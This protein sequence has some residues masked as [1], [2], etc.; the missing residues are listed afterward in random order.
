LGA[1]GKGTCSRLGHAWV[2]RGVRTAGACTL[3]IL[4]AGAVSSC[5]TRSAHRV[6]D[7]AHGI[8]D[9]DAFKRM[10]HALFDAYDRA[11]PDRFAEEV[12]PAFVLIDDGRADDR[13]AVIGEIR[14]RRDRHAPNRSRTTKNEKVWMGKSSAVFF[15]ETIEHFLPDGPRIVGDVDGYVTLVWTND[16]GLWKVASWQWIQGGLEADRAAWNATYADS[17]AGRA[18]TASGRW[19]NPE[20]NMFLVEMVRARKPG[21]AL[22]VAMGQGRNALYLASEGWHVTGID[23]SDEALREARQAAFERQLQIDVQNVEAAT[24]EFGTARWDLVT[25]IYAAGCPRPSEGEACGVRIIEKLRRGM[26]QGGLVVVEGPHKD[27]RPWGFSDGELST[28]FKEGFTVMRDEV[29]DDVSDWGNQAGIRQKL[30][31]F[32]ATRD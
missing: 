23:I 28:L 24:W 26:K 25:F 13:G 5:N 7:A 1:N 11:D 6:P 17:L 12:G 8:L 27:A 4:A 18:P 10:A 30:V 9:E 19:Y 20:P 32:A 16:A 3:G 29:V 22:D 14:A 2:Q 15:G 21:F 31:R